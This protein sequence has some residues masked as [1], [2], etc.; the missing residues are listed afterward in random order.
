MVNMNAVVLY[1]SPSDAAALLGVSYSTVHRLI[2]EGEIPAKRF[3]RTLKI[4]ADGLQKYID[5]SDVKRV[6]GNKE[7]VSH[8]CT[9]TTC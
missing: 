6:N 2:S 5:R 1:L 8:S 4:P 3:R 9:R 7:L